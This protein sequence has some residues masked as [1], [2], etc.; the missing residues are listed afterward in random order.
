MRQRRVGKTNLF[1]TEMGFGGASI[2][3]LYT[4]AQTKEVNDVMAACWDLGIRYFDTAP[5]YGHGLSERRMGDGLRQHPRK[6]FVLSTKVGDF[7]YA[8]HDEL[9][10]V[11]KFIDKLPFHLKF[12]YSYDGVMRAF[13]DSLQ[14]LGLHR[15][16]ILLVHDLDPI[17]HS[18]TDFTQHLKTY[19]DG[20]YKALDE[21][22][23]AG[24][25]S[26]MGL[27]VK[28]WEVC[29]EALKYGTYECFML[30]GN[31][32]LLEQPA[33]DNHFM[34]VCEKKQISILLAGAYASGI[35]ATG[36]VKGAYF[37]HKEASDAILAKVR[38]IETICAEH[39]VPI[40]AAALQFPLLHPSVAAVVVGCASAEL[41]R[42]NIEYY[43]LPVPKSLW[44]ALKNENII[45]R[46]APIERA[47]I[48][49]QEL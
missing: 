49:L 8:R 12:D 46:H 36:A 6:E 43:H 45:S 41:M 39:T 22:R 18:P 47:D 40:Q 20:G 5:E 15:V 13:E 42:K 26:A 38:L 48:E 23:A 34:D 14:R 3:N 29:A 16:D 32:T 4:P 44:E 28:Q 31:Y 30:Q 11:N 33:L 19:L 27:G 17:I 24:M 9:P 21:L 37:H 25:I 35:L 7:L 2:G 1:V 10:S